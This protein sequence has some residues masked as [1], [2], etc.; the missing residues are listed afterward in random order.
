MQ[1]LSEFD[2]DAIDFHQW[3]QWFKTRSLVGPCCKDWNEC[4]GVLPCFLSSVLFESSFSWFL[5]ED[6]SG[7]FN[8]QG[9][10]EDQGDAFV[11]FLFSLGQHAALG[12]ISRRLIVRFLDDIWFVTKP[13][14]SRHNLAEREMW[15]EAWIQVHTEDSRLQPFRNNTSRVRRHSTASSG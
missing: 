3:H 6:D 12:A 7:E 10:G 2:T 14:A 1:V 13:R 4:Q 5:W 11:P 8:P 15:R 9:E